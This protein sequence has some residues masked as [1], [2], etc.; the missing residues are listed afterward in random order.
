MKNT[1]LFF[2]LLALVALI[3]SCDKKNDDNPEPSPNPNPNPSEVVIEIQVDFSSK[4]DDIT[5]NF[6]QNAIALHDQN[7]SGIAIIPYTQPISTLRL[8]GEQAKQYL[9]KK[10]YVYFEAVRSNGHASAFLKVEKKIEPLLA[11]PAINKLV[12]PVLPVSA[13][14]C[15]Y[16]DP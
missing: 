6:I 4:P 8:T 11:L 3:S 2:L 16:I 12:I 14:N 7:W 9:G 10:V 15:E 13:G 1:K 5:L